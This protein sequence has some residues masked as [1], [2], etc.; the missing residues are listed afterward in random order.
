MSRIFTR[1]S[2]LLTSAGLPALAVGSSLLGGSSFALA[3]P[4]KASKTYGA[5]GPTVRSGG[6]TLGK[7]LRPI[8][9][10]VLQKARH[11]F[12]IAAANP[13][14]S[15]AK[16][17]MAAAAAKFMKAQ[18]SVRFK[19]ASTRAGVRLS[20][21]DSEWKAAFGPY[22]KVAP[23]EF[24]RTLSPGEKYGV[25]LEAVVEKSKAGTKKVKIRREKP[26]KYDPA[27]YEAK[28][29]YARIAFHLNR[30]KCIVDTNEFDSDEIRIGG[31]LIRPDGK[32]TDVANHLVF[33]DFD[34]GDTRNYDHSACIG[35]PAS[36]RKGLEQLGMCAGSASDPW[37]GRVL[38]SAPLDG[39]WPG[40]FGLVLLMVDEDHGGMN[41]LLSEL[42]SRI[43]EELDEAIASLGEAAGDAVAEY[44]GEDIGAIVNEIVVWAL[45][46]LVAWVVSL[47]DNIDDPIS[48]ESWIVTLPNRTREAIDALASGGVDT[49]SGSCGSKIEEIVF[50]GDGGKY[51]ADLHWRALA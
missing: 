14:R 47:F 4:A 38:A 9:E 36:Q 15:F 32:I 35:K 17:G 7:P 51:R 24:E 40:T 28:P 29:R 23:A 34:P 44:L 43:K 5:A 27:D 8:A 6:Q 37:A 25:P 46:E 20:S 13:K 18:S 41:E 1:R 50:Q 16:G 22:G 11:A 49:P 10:Q 33:E 31:H 30:V 21:G 2:M 12:T 39:P 48:G 19:R 42:Y 26:K 45:T 3:A